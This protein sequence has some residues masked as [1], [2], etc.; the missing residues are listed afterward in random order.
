MKALVGGA[1][2]LHAPG[3]AAPS[4]GAGLQPRRDEAGRRGPLTIRRSFSGT[5]GGGAPTSL[6]GNEISPRGSNVAGLVGRRPPRDRPLLRSR[7][8]GARLVGRREAAANDRVR[9]AHRWQVGKEHVFGGDARKASRGAVRCCCGPGGSGRPGERLSAASRRAP[10]GLR[11]ECLPAGRDGLRVCARWRALRAFSAPGHGRRRPA[12]RASRH[13]HRPSSRADGA[14]GIGCS[15][16]TSR[17]RRASGRWRR[18]RL[19]LEARHPPARHRA[20]GGLR[21]RRSAGSTARLG[22]QEAPRCGI[23]RRCPEPGRSS[24]A[25][26]GPGTWRGVDAAPEGDWLTAFQIVELRATFWPLRSATRGR[27]RVPPITRPV[28][29]SPDGRWLATSW[30]DRKL[31]LWPMPGTGGREP[32]TLDLPETRSGRSIA[33]DPRGRY[34]FAVGHSD[35]AWIVPLDGSRPRRLPVYSEDTPLAQRR[36]RRADGGSPRP[37]A[38]AWAR[39]RCGCTTWRRARPACSRCRRTP[40]S[41]RSRGA[42]DVAWR[43]PSTPSRLRRRGDA[44]YVRWAGL[45]RWDLKSGTSALVGSRTST[46]GLPRRR[47][48]PRA[49]RRRSVDGRRR[50][51]S[52]AAAGDA[53]LGLRD[54]ETARRLRSAHCVVGS[55][56]PPARSWPRRAP[57]G[58]LVGR[59]STAAPPTFSWGTKGPSP[60]W[61]SRPTDAGSRRA[62]RTTRCASGRCRISRSPRCTRC[63]TTSS[64]AKLKSLTNLRV[65]RDPEVA[66]RL[67]DRHRPV[68]RLEGRADVVTAVSF[69]EA[70]ARHA[71]IPRSFGSPGDEESADAGGAARLRADRE[72]MVKLRGFQ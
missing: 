6:E 7:D 36:S 5:T 15:R 53:R 64:L 23:S 8:E 57:T 69:R 63:P 25:E 55:R 10:L 20:P 54:D 70:P 12:R 26:A 49:H 33:F 1:A 65:V 67:E 32:R 29:F 58:V 27:R 59:L 21:R 13:R 24:S 22:R 17:A 34:L 42:T 62:A 28:A 9:R 60:P 45:R 40:A 68:P 4:A 56:R 71:V 51:R 50:A 46:S 72:I 47:P 61:P 35:R 2:E 43:T 11:P 3:G 52:C 48:T 14:R 41:R 18:G 30:A 37:G 66:R 44:L 16:T 38:T 39:R 31:R 19:E